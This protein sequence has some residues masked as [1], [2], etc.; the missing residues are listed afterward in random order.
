[1]QRVDKTERKYISHTLNKDC[2]RAKEKNKHFRNKHHNI[3]LHVSCAQ[4]VLIDSLLTIDTKSPDQ[5]V[6]QQLRATFTHELFKLLMTSYYTITCSRCEISDD[7]IVLFWDVHG[8][9]RYERCDYNNI[10]NSFLS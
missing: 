5:F 2:S 6:T 7:V 8:H 4:A 10:N 1:M 9:E 3:Y